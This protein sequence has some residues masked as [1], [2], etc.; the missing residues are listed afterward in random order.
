MHNTI[1]DK[2][3]FIFGMNLIYTLHTVLRFFQMFSGAACIRKFV[4]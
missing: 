3:E 4:I 1:K 2:E